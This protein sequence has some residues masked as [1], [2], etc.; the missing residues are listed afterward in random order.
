MNQVQPSNPATRYDYARQSVANAYC[1][2]VQLRNNPFLYEEGHEDFFDQPRVAWWFG[3]LDQKIKEE[4]GYT[5]GIFLD[6]EGECG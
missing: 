4:T 6:C 5:D 2:G 3:W 1:D